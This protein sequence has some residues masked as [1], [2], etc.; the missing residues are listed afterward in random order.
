LAGRARFAG[1]ELLVRVNDRL[2]D[3]DE[4]GAAALRGLLAELV[5]QL[6]PGLAVQMAPGAADPRALLSVRVRAPGAPEL[7]ALI[8][9]LRRPA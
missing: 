7:A 4:A 3:N 9:R 2:I 6:Y 5:G 1:D 8:D